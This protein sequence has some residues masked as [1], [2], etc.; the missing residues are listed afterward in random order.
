MDDIIEN[1]KN[2]KWVVCKLCGS[3]VLRPCAASHEQR[4]VLNLRSSKYLIDPC[5]IKIEPCNRSNLC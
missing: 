2:K 1:G 5:L 3:K 4:E